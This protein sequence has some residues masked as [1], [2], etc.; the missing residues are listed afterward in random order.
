MNWEF[1]WKVLSDSFS[2]PY[3]QAQSLNTRNTTP[4]RQA[5]HRWGNRLHEH[6]ISGRRGWGHLGFGLHWSLTLSWKVAGTLSFCLQIE[7]PGFEPP[8]HSCPGRSPSLPWPR[9]PGLFQSAGPHHSA[10]IELRSPHPLHGPAQARHSCPL[11]L[12]IGRTLYR[13]SLKANHSFRQSSS[14]CGLVKIGAGQS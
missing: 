10:Q 5:P 2:Q 7:G 4:G 13:P 3:F 6:R 9:Q 8:A 1:R 11:R 12:P 14:A